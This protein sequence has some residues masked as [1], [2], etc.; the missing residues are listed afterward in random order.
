MTF[1]DQAVPSD[2]SGVGRRNRLF[3]PVASFL[4]D[5]AWETVV[6]LLP[7]F[8]V[9]VLGASALAVGVVEGVGDATSTVAKLVSGILAD[10]TGS[11]KRL[12][13][14]GYLLAGLSR[15]LLY[16]VTFW[17]GAL[18]I[19]FTERLGKGIRTSPRDAL[20]AD[21]TPEGETGRAFGWLRT[22]DTLG[23]FGSML[24]GLLVIY[25][26]QGNAGQLRSETFR[27][28]VLVATVPGLLALVTIL[29][30]IRDVPA[31]T[32]VGLDLAARQ[33]LPRSFFGYTAIAAVFT[34][35]NSS[36]A[37][38]I[39]RAQN[40]GGST[41]LIVAL[42]AGFNF[43]YAALSR[44]LGGL[45]DR[46]GKHWVIAGGW[47]LYAGTYFGFGVTSSFFWLALLLVPYGVYYAA[48]EGVTRA[49][50]AD[51]V[52]SGSRGAAFGIFN[53]ALGASALFGSLIAGA[54][55]S[56]I[57]PAAPFYVGAGLAAVSGAMM[58][59]LAMR[60]DRG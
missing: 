51:V 21:S 56:S 41:L 26:V 5:F 19:R 23:A 59:V 22:G 12:T 47:L 16:F 34:L 14:A 58:L 39:L 24:V 38:I 3:L 15:P 9:N 44:P 2:P 32:R 17:Q 37:F 55:Y 35:A 18:V 52:P 27:T 29:V 50:V 25:M 10:R 45:S 11:R 31:R 33:G 54:L 1:P 43:V 8:I 20:L 30:A 28:L 13:A 48:T 57:S 53:G 40:V 49:L 60:R 4:N 46:I 36:D 42:F 6:M 7:L